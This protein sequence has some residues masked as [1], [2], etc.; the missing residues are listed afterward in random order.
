MAKEAGLEWIHQSGTKKPVDFPS[1]IRA[2]AE[3]HTE[4]VGYEEGSLEEYQ[5]FANKRNYSLGRA[6]IGEL[7]EQ[8]GWDNHHSQFDTR[9]EKFAELIVRECAHELVRWNGEPF[10]YDPEFGARLIKQHFGVD[11]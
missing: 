9:I 3:I 10:P 2:G 1:Q 7:A 8:A 11:G 5:K 6:R 4:D